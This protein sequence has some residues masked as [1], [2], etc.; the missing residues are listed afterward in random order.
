MLAF[1]DCRTYCA[2]NMAVWTSNTRD[3]LIQS[4]PTWLKLCSVR[5]YVVR[6]DGP[7]GKPIMLDIGPVVPFVWRERSLTPLDSTAYVV[8]YCSVGS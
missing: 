3:S 5:I 6:F 1:P 8:C 2:P 7:V 4:A